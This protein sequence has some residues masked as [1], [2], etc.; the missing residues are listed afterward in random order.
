MSEWMLLNTKWKIF[1]LYHGENKLHSIK[2]HWWCPR[3][4]RPTSKTQLEIFGLTQPGLEPT[5]YRS[6]D[7]HANHYTTDAV[8]SSFQNFCLSSW[9]GQ[10]LRKCQFLNWC[11][12]CFHGLLRNIKGFELSGKIRLKFTKN[13]SLRII[14]EITFLGSR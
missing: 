3:C 8:W 9:I 5:S 12:A 10:L 7:E 6:R 13:E 1:Q 14:R 4:T 11:Q 2:W